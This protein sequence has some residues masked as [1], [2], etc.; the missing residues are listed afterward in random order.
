M[1]TF[2]SAVVRVNKPSW[3]RASYPSVFASSAV[4]A[5]TGNFFGCD[6]IHAGKTLKCWLIA[7]LYWRSELPPLLH[8]ASEIPQMKAKNPRLNRRSNVMK[9]SN[10]RG[11]N[12]DGYRQN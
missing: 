2:F 4:A 7:V 9:V 5:C 10:W 11:T 1:K 3:V 6:Q 12:W 8:A